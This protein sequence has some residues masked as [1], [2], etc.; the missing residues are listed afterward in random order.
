[1]R[2]EL[3]DASALVDYTVDGV[4][5][6]KR[7]QRYTFRRASAAGAFEGATIQPSAGGSTVGGR[8]DWTLMIRDDG[9]RVDMDVSSDSSY[10]TYTGSASHDGQFEN[11]S[12][13]YTCP[14]RSGSWSMRVDPTTEGLTGTF[15]GPDVP[16]GR[17]AAA[18][19]AGQV[20]M[21]GHGWRNDMWF[22]PGESGWGL[23]V[24]EQGNILFATLFVYDPQGRPRWYVA[25]DLAQ[26][27]DSPDG[28]VLYTGALLESTGPYFGGP[29]DP[30]AVTR[31]QVGPMQ[32]TARAD[33]SGELSYAVDGVV[34]TKRLQRFAFRKQV[35]SG[36]YLGTWGHDRPATIA[37]DDDG[38][39]FRMQVVDEI[40][41]FGTCDFVAP[42]SQTGSLRT[43]AGTFTCRSGAA[44]S[45]TLRH[46]TVSAHGFTARFDSPAYGFRSIVDGHLGGARR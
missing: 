11:V 19:F 40:G 30:A 4:R 15:S 18:R 16:T 33:G 29:F 5:V 3:G 1:M 7:V 21:Q 6:S 2:F 27:G 13:T 36:A 20:R 9:S 35:F 24:I 10:C 38:A 28:A 12:G 45:F 17:I 37:I 39:D 22:V 25:S 44:G 46:A 23:S 41:G 34:V 32:F 42:F 43:M 31:R 8:H 14:G 26:Q